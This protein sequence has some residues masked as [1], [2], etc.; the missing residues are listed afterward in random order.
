[1]QPPDKVSDYLS[2]E[3][4]DV[5]S[6]LKLAEEFVEANQFL[7]TQDLYNRARRVLKLP[8]KTLKDIIFFLTRTNML[9]EGSKFTRVTVLN[10]EFRKKIYD[11]IKEN[12]GVHFSFLKRQVAAGSPGQ[13]IWNLGLLEKFHHIKRLREGNNTLF[14]PYD[15][16]PEA[17]VLHHLIKD[18][19]NRDLFGLLLKFDF[20]Q[21]SDCCKELKYKSKDIYYRILKLME[22]QILVA[23]PAR[24]RIG[25]NSLKRKLI[26]KIL[27]KE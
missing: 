24:E 9:V 7:E 1:M 14:L 12:D 2:L 21:K 22:S 3:N 17:G 11:L 6:V 5:Q 27:L 18:P 10:N 19:I 8:S 13:L 20:M 16:E 23:D 26:Q 25:I 4:P 15:M